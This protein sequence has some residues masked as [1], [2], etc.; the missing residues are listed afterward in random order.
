[1]TNGINNFLTLEEKSFIGYITELTYDSAKI[2]SHDF[3]VSRANFIPKGSFL[4]VK[5]DMP[6][7][8]ILDLKIMECDSHHKIYKK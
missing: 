1:M 8:H 6:I 5:V 2:L 4:L 7:Q 3:Q